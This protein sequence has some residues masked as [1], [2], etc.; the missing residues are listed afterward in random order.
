[1]TELTTQDDPQEP[2][3]S[4]KWFVIGMVIFGMIMTSGIWIYWR[5]HLAPFLELQQALADK[6]EDSR[7]IVEGGQ[8]KMH[9][10]TPTI[11]RVTMKVDYDPT[12]QPEAVDRLFEEVLAL[13]KVKLS[14]EPYQLFEMNVY[15]PK[16]ET[17]L[18][19][20]KAQRTRELKAPAES[21][22]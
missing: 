20:I 11:L 8:S 9:K 21:A 18:T 1:M 3:I 13:A 15:L 12:L 4:G 5:L 22:K 17:E 10:N 19:P 6:Y 2:G 14:L 7:P 16:Q